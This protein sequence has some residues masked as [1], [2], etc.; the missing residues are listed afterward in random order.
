[1]YDEDLDHAY[2]EGRLDASNGKRSAAD[3]LPAELKYA[4]QAGYDDYYLAG[5]LTYVKG[6]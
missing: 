3:C 5:A 4:Y 6:D 2:E 1:M